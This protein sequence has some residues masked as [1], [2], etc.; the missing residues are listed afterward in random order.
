MNKTQ[1]LIMLGIYGGTFV[2]LSGVIVGTVIASPLLLAGKGL[3]FAAESWDSRLSRR[4]ILRR[5]YA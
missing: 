4:E 5:N 1:K 3:I 2:L